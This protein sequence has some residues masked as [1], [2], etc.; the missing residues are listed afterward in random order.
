MKSFDKNLRVL[1]IALAVAMS[2]MALSACNAGASDGPIQHGS[3]SNYSGYIESGTKFGVSIGDPIES[4]QPKLTSQGMRYDGISHCESYPKQLLNCQSSD[5][6]QGYRVQ[7]FLKDGFVYVKYEGGRVT[8]I[9]W[10][11]SLFPPMEL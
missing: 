3:N 4:V 2:G 9:A 6:W 1:G 8:V 10:S 11:F 7:K 5:T